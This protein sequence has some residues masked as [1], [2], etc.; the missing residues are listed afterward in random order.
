MIITDVDLGGA[1]DGMPTFGEPSGNGRM[2]LA[3][4]RELDQT[5]EVIQRE[6]RE[7][8]PRSS[9]CHVPDGK[10]VFCPSSLC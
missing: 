5:V 8:L 2:N 1:I 9:P 7:A 10:V 6:R 4:L 3:V